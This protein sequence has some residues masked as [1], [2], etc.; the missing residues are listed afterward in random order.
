MYRT[1]NPLL[2]WIWIGIKFW[3]GQPWCL[4]S[5]A[6]SK[7]KLLKLHQS[8]KPNHS[9]GLKT[10]TE[11]FP[12][13]I[14]LF[15]AVSMLPSCS[16][17]SEQHIYKYHQKGSANSTSRPDWKHSQESRLSA[18]WQEV[19]RSLIIFGVYPN[20]FG[21]AQYLLNCKHCSD[22]LNG[23]SHVL[24]VKH[25]LKHVAESGPQSVTFLDV[26]TTTA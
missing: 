18:D 15:H 20:Q 3:D 23:T 16:W 2:I 4:V 25:T 11:H 10:F 1:Q 19:W 12:H 7:K 21:K 8:P 17:D 14:F 6:I 9:W 13:I 26:P 5:G 24:K 22:I